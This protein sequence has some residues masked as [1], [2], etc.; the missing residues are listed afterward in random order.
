MTLFGMDWS[1]SE[2]IVLF[3]IL[4]ISSVFIIDYFWYY[5]LLVETAKIC[6][7]FEIDRGIQ[8]RLSNQ[9]GSRVTVSRSNLVLMA[10]YAVPVVAGI[11][12]L[13]VM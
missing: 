8:C 9:I 11:V 4:F 6:A 12:L 1:S 3:A 2:S 5:R 7:E 10:Y 13:R